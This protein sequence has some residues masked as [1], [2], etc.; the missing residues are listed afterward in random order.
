M[1]NKFFSDSIWKLLFLFFHRMISAI[2]SPFLVVAPFVVHYHLPT[3]FHHAHVIS[4]RIPESWWAANK[5]LRFS[6]SLA[7]NRLTSGRGQGMFELL[8]GPCPC[9]CTTHWVLYSTRLVYN[10]VD[11][12]TEWKVREM[13]TAV[14]P[15]DPQN[16]SIRLSIAFYVVVCTEIYTALLA[17]VGRSLCNLHSLIHIYNYIFMCFYVLSLPTF[18]FRSIKFV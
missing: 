7:I 5:A 12:H 18:Y 15:D 3:A 14:C 11:V 10:I 2:S 8:W 6:F 13:Q 9:C 4:S 16:L 17:A 1:R